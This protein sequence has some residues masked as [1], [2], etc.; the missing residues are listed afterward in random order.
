MGTQQ[1]CQNYTQVLLS[2][3]G[4]IEEMTGEMEK[5]KK[6]KIIQKR[7]IQGEITMEDRTSRVCPIL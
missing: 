4:Q 2:N 6:K 5:K 3:P 7:L 1:V